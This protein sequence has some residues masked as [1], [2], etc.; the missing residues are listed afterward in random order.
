LLADYLPW[1][2]TIKLP[3]PPPETPECR[4]PADT[5]SLQLAI[6]G[7]ADVLVT[8]DKDVL[9]LVGILACPILTAEAFLA[10]Q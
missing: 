6:A 1:C 4:D 7:K 9:V 10:Q 3:N 5:P 8:G 2:D